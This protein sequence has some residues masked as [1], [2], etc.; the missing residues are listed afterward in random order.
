MADSQRLIQR[1][2]NVLADVQMKQ[3]Q[4]QKKTIEFLKY[5]LSN[6]PHPDFM[7]NI[8]IVQ[9]GSIYSGATISLQNTD[10]NSSV[11]V[12]N[13]SLSKSSVLPQL[14]APG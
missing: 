4:E 12:A 5:S 13:N 9:G 7:K 2:K 6:R 10:C 8:P 1:N 11:I 3:Q 14:L